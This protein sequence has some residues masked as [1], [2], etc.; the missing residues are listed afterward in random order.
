[1]FLQRRGHV[2]VKGQYG[3]TKGVYCIMVNFPPMREKGS[4]ALVPSLKRVL[5]FFFI[6]DVMNFE[7]EG[8]V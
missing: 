6:P 3:K 4:R 7:F 8:G 1:M 5:G 2:N